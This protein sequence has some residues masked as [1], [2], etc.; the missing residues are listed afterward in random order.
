M[1]QLPGI[2]FQARAAYT[3]NRFAL[4]KCMRQHPK[5]TVVFLCI[6]LMIGK[7]WKAPFP[8]ECI[9]F[10]CLDKKS[11][12]AKGGMSTVGYFYGSLEHSD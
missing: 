5:N 6:V 7:G 12:L 9:T 1:V 4:Y 11:F 2:F 8:R 10:P 3:W